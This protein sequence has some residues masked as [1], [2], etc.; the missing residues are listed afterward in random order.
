MILSDRFAPR[1][2]N[3]SSVLDDPHRDL[4]PLR[5][6]VQL[7]L[8]YPTK[9]IPRE[10]PTIPDDDRSLML[11][12][13]HHVLHLRP[14]LV[15]ADEEDRRHVVETVLLPPGAKTFE[16]L[17]LVEKQ[18]LLALLHLGANLVGGLLLREANDLSEHGT[19]LVG[20]SRC[21][22]WA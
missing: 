19:S 17:V 13:P 22:A 16:V 10:L 5:E 18:D 21:A 11:A 4:A 6:I 1:R 7:A 12:D 9:G 3:L 20:S 14:L 15:G 2:A 8:Q